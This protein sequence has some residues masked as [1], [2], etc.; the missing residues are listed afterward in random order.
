MPAEFRNNFPQGRKEAESKKN[1]IVL[2]CCLCGIAG[3][4]SFPSLPESVYDAVLEHELTKRGLAV[5]TRQP[6]PFV[7][8]DV[9]L[10]IGFRADGIVRVVNN[11]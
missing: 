9:K 2:L 1:E 8:E 6:M 7:W 5:V 4:L 10:E 11:L 3:E